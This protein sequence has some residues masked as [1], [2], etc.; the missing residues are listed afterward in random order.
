MPARISG[1]CSAA[2]CNLSEFG[3]VIPKVSPNG[4]SSSEFDVF[5]L[6]RYAYASRDVRDV[7][8]VPCVRRRAR[9]RSI[10]RVRSE[11]PEIGLSLRRF[12]RN[13]LLLHFPWVRVPRPVDIAMSFLQ[14]LCT[15]LMEYQE[16]LEYMAMSSSDKV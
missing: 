7:R 3:N 15:R 4:K 2:F 14:V 1:L 16:F 9:D 13:F 11:G 5:A 12:R 10:G 8:D 6:S